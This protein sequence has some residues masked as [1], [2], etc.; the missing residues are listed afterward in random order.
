MK[1][2]NQPPLSFEERRKIKELHDKGFKGMAIS[3]QLGRGKN[4]VLVEL[5][6]FHGRTY[7][8]EIAQKEANE[9]V[10]KRYESVSN[11]LRKNPTPNPYQAL[12]KRI[13]CLEMQ[14]EILMDTI[15]EMRR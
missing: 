13:E 4:T 14:V 7:D 6:R 10:I 8:P 5:R 2:T 11:T 1:R 3:Q 9:R 12:L 15:K